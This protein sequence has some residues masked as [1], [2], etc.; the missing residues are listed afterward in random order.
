MSGWLESVNPDIVCLQE[1]KAMPEQFDRKLFEQIGYNS[2][3]H[4]ATK[5]GCGNLIGPATNH[6]GAERA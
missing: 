4:S 5:K 6:H 2:F 3:I 1:I